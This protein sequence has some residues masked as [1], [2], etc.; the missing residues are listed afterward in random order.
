MHS[1]PR[2][3]DVNAGGR[4]GMKAAW[5]EKNGPARD[6]LRVGTMETPHPGAGEVRVR[7]HYAGINPSDVKRRAGWNNQRIPFP[8]VVPQMD[9]SGVIDEV[10]EGVDRHRV[11]ERVWLHSTGWKRPFGTAAE[12]AVTPQDRALPLPERI[13]LRVG[14]SLGVPAL[15][16]HR[17]VF[18]QGSVSG[19]TVLVTGGAGAVGFYAIQLARWG[20]ARVLATASG[21]VKNEE[22]LRAGAE[23][24]VD[25]RRE[26][27]AA[28]VLELTGG[29]GVDHLVEVDFGANLPVTLKVLKPHG[30]IA[31][32]AS[33]GQPLPAIPFYEMMNRNL[34]LLW[35]FVYELPEPVLAQAGLEIYA[36]LD[37]GQAKFPALHEYPLDEIAAA[38]EAVEA[39]ALGKVVVRIGEPS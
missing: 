9:G 5:Y 23:A 6:V 15:T 34:R 20:G 10:G 29:H 31:T 35:V 27:V 16:A 37:G 21:G 7:V 24:V 4:F 18:G 19:R 32:Y 2:A 22:A 12:Y 25:Y 39:G 28:R 11:G 3:G 1:I 30:S 33:M 13:D 17:A 38:H 26:D 8:R 14:A 36:W